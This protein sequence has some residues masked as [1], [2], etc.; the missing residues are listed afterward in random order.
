MGY[1]IT[2]IT[3]VYNVEN[4]VA[5]TIESVIAQDIGFQNIQL[6]MVDDGS[7]DKSGDICDAYAAKYPDNIKVIHKE[8][9]GASSARNE[10]LKHIE[11]KYVSFLDADD[12]LSQNA[13]SACARFLD[14]HPETDVA[15]MPVFYF[16]GNKG[17]HPLNGKFNKGTR[18]IDLKNDWKNNSQLSLSSALTRAESFN[19]LRFDTGLSYAEDAQLLQKILSEKQT[20][21]VVSEA[22]YYYRRRSAGERS[23]IQSGIGKR[24]WYLPYMERF[25]LV[26]V[27]YYLKKFGRVPEFIQNT[28]I[29]DLQWRVRSEIP[30]NLLS[31]EEKKRYLGEIVEVLQYI[32]DKVIL[33]QEFINTDIKSLVFSLKYD[34]RKASRG[35]KNKIVYEN[36]NISAI[37]EFGELKKDALVL[38]GTL[39]GPR[40]AKQ[41]SVLE[42]CAGTAIY[43]CGCY[44]RLSPEKGVTGEVP[45][46]TSFR[47]KIGT[48]D[49]KEK[50]EIRICVNTAGKTSD[51]DNIVFSKFFPISDKYEASYFAGKGGI[52][53]KTENCFSIGPYSKRAERAAAAKLNRELFKTGGA[54]EKKALVARAICGCVRPFLRKPLWLISDRPMSAGDNGEALFR[55]IRKEHPE[56][57]A[58]FVVGKKSKAYEE[59]K[60]AGPVIAFDSLEHKI[61][62]LL[63][64]Y[65]ISS[66]GGNIAFNPAEKLSLACKDIHSNTKYVFLQHGVIKDDLSQWLSRYNK[67]YSGFVTSAKEEYESIV[68]G[69]YGYPKDNIWLTGLP[70]FDRLY[71]DEQNW[72]TVMPTWRRY[73][74]GQLDPNTGKWSL[75]QNAEESSYIR[76]YRDLL[77]SRRLLEAAEQLNYKIRFMPHPNMQ[78]YPELFHAD[79]RVKFLDSSTPYR[80]VY[81]KSDL[82]VTDYSSAVFDFAYLRKPVLYTQ[83][84][85]EEF[86]KG[87]HTYTKGY[88][89]YERDGFGEVE[90]D[91]DSTVD[92]IIE[93]MENGCRLKEKYRE[94][95]DSF[96]AFDDQNNCRRVFGKLTELRA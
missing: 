36:G 96:F 78:P 88:F 77:N 5:E 68:N 75:D 48:E 61:C 79:K 2:V 69:K 35:E 55:Y 40:S 33:A 24:E 12:K 64:D 30:D 57:D 29:Y 62:F 14:Y 42:I 65:M 31:G 49:I 1:I 85:S 11:G 15:A 28:L 27:D 13:L 10:G 38:E 17:Q 22:K 67:N 74:M 58:R 26:T 43:K 87:E 6:I 71:R 37:L 16:D 47:A 32:D 50:T 56:I 70:R 89:D 81:A 93:Y 52:I 84:D 7:A 51:L 53:Q 92:R 91:L 63:S 83:F 18:V 94:R 90:Y 95:M 60:K 41:K 23:A 82:V 46:V 72:I 76:F 19:G 86:F 34:H 39:L 80:E 4:Y 8:N 3:A 25:Q 9:C 54:V 45:P 59:L 21:G 66:A 44:E 73:L 20:L